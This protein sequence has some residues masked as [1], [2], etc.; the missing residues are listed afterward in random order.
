MQLL[1]VQQAFGIF[2]PTV[3]SS[4]IPNILKEEG[5]D[6]GET[7][8]TPRSSSSRFLRH[9]AATNFFHDMDANTKRHTRQLPSIARSQGDI[10]KDNANSNNVQNMTKVSN[11]QNT[12][13]NNN[14]AKGQKAKA[15]KGVW[16]ED[17]KTHKMENNRPTSTEPSPA[18][19][20]FSEEIGDEDEDVVSQEVET[21]EPTGGAEDESFAR[22]K[23][24]EEEEEEEEEESITSPEEVERRPEPTNSESEY[25]SEESKLTSPKA[26]TDDFEDEEEATEEAAKVEEYEKE[27]EKLEKELSMEKR[28]VRRIGGFSFLLA[29]IAMVVTAQQMSENPDGIYA[30]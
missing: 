9:R 6:N 28:E 22:D 15:A 20:P 30:R 16:M 23:D 1:L 12:M 2:L 29:V 26:N 8:P 11:D 25:P 5:V 13:T 27:E 24:D 4:N 21:T 14:N 10:Q 19:S 7:T 18:P 3:A 17:E